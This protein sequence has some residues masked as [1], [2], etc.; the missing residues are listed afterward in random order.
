MTTAK[1]QFDDL[2]RRLRDPLKLR[3]VLTSC[4]LA[5][6]Y[7]GIY[8][9]MNGLI[10]RASRDLKKEETRRDLADEIANLRPQLDAFKERLPESKEVNDWVQYVL[11][12]I[13]QFP[14]RVGTLA[15]KSTQRLGPYEAVVLYIELDGGYRDLAALLAWLEAN[16]RITRVDAVKITPGR[17][18]EDKYNMQLTV[19]G[20]MR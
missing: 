17:T 20:M 14:L 5:I 11:D 9:P 19:L 16:R 4:M 10:D 12:G 1:S 8:E 2:L 15:P 18:E 3:V 6:G 7:V 13:R